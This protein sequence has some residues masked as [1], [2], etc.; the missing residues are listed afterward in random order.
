MQSKDSICPVCEEYYFEFP[1]DYDI[2][3]ICGW[4]ND[5]L[6]RDQKDLWGGANNLSVNEAK[7]VY[8]LLLGEETKSKVFKIIDEYDHRQREIHI[9]YAEI[10]HRTSEGE[11]CRKAFAQAHDDFISELDKL[12]NGIDFKG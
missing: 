11:K 8:S 6:Q 3:P 10:D 2:C 1:F 12:V 5:G 7:I 4:E 9:Q